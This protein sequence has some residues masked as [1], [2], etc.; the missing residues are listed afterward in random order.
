[1][2]ENWEVVNL[3]GRGRGLLARCDIAG[4]DKI[5]QE[6]ALSAVTVEEWSL[7]VCHQCFRMAA[8]FSRCAD[9]KHVG[10]C[11]KECEIVGAAT[12]H[13]GG[14]YSECN[15]LARLDTDI[16]RD[17]DAALA[18]LFVKLLCRRAV[19]LAGLVGDEEEGS[20][21][22][23]SMS[24]LESNAEAVSED[25]MSDIAMI[26]EVVLEAL[27]PAARIEQEVLEAYMY[28]EQCNSFGIWGQSGRSQGKLVGFGIFPGLC[29]FNHSCLPN[30]T[31]SQTVGGT[32]RTLTAHAL[33]P[34]AAGEE[35][36][37]SYSEAKLLDDKSQ[38]QAWLNKTYMFECACQLCRAP[39][40]EARELVRGF[41]KRSYWRLATS[42]SFAR[43]CCKTY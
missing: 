13:K 16:L 30:V 35:L 2:Q 9:C 25:R 21:V 26:A 14:D 3:G 37:I 20:K 24:V 7:G 36:C 6:V 1:M 10:W 11:S 32:I 4:G 28:A 15:A 12:H 19:E 29:M 17:G 41:N 18:K 43:A 23:R 34:V 33:A 38:R 42:V 27:H 31:I 8:R 39:P 40:A 22:E 5:L